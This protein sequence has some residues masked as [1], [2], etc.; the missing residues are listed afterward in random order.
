MGVVHLIRHGQASFGSDDYDVLSPIGE[1]QSSALGQGWEAEGFVPT[2]AVAGSMKRHA[3]TAIAAI[4]ACGGPD[5]YDV[6]AGWNEYDHVGIATAHDAGAL[7][8]DSKAFQRLLNQAIADWRSG[9]GEYDE[10][11]SVFVERVMGAF[12]AAVATAGPG[13]SVAVFTSGGPIAMIVS[14]LLTGDDALFQRLNDVI[15]NASV[16][17]VISGSTGP[18]LLSFNEHTHLARDLVTYR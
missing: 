15:I 1:T 3:Q 14:H 6:D 18:R 13:R 8:L 16:T 10:P 2:D 11:Y 5:G 7:G 12:D 9:V 17:T 4:D